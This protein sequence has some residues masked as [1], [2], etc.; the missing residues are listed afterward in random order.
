MA[1]KVVGQK[2][3]RKKSTAEEARKTGET[4]VKRENLSGH[5]IYLNK[6]YKR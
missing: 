3:Y 4:T 5:K 6:R 1:I 2:F